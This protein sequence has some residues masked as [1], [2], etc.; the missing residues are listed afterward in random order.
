MKV[1][2]EWIEQIAFYSV[3]MVLVNHL[4]PAGEQKKYVRFFM[5]LVFLLVVFAPILRITGQEAKIY[6]RY[7]EHSYQQE[8]KSFQADQGRMERDLEHYI[9]EL[10]T[11][12]EVSGDGAGTGKGEYGSDTKE[13]VEIKIGEIKVSP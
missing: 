13:P 3:L 8:W 12:G 10:L 11:R 2:F 5:G 6:R 9:Q 1:V 4:L 7:M